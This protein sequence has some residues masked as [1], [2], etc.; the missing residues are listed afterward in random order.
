MTITGQGMLNHDRVVTRRVEGPPRLI[1]D[2]HLREGSASFEL[3]ATDVH[4]VPRPLR[5]PLAPGSGRPGV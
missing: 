5:G 2:T 3:K 1:G 4:M